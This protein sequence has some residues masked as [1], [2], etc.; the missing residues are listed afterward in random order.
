MNNRFWQLLLVG[1]SL[2]VTL[3][4]QTTIKLSKTTLYERRFSIS[5]DSVEMIFQLPDSFLIAGSDSF[6]LDSVWLEPGNDYLLDLIKGRLI[7]KKSI[8]KGKILHLQYE[9]LPLKLPTQFYH[10]RLARLRPEDDNLGK[11]L[12][13][14]NIFRPMDPEPS[15][16]TTSNLQKSGSIVR[17]ISVGSNQG[18]KLDSGLR[19][20]ISGRI[21]D[22][23]DVIAALTDQNTPIQPEGNTQSLQEIDKVFVQV[24]SNQFEATLGDYQLQF[25]SGEF[26]RYARKLQGAM[27]MV[28]FNNVEVTFSGAISRGQYTTNQFLGQEGNQGPYQLKGTQGQID[29]IV[30]AGTERVWIDGQEMTRGETNDYVIEYGNGQIIFTRNRL[31]TAESRI[32]VDFQYSDQKF[33]R[34]LYAGQVKASFFNQRLQ[35]STLYL[36]ESDDKDNPLDF[37]LTPEISNRLARAGDKM[38]SAYVESQQ[39][40]GKRKGTYIQVD[41]ADVQFYRYVGSEKGDYQVNFSF[42][43]YGRG[44]YQLQGFGKYRFVGMG[45]GS[46]VAKVL[47][48]PAISQNLVDFNLKY[49]PASFFEMNQELAISHFD[50]NI[51]SGLDDQDNQGFAYQGL[52][53]LKPDRIKYLGLF[54]LN[55]KFRYINP[56]FKNIDRTSEVEFNRKW[57]LKN[58]S[59]V[60]EAITE[61]NGSYTPWQPLDFQL[62]FGEIE[63]GNSFRSSRYEFNSQLKAP[64]LPDYQYRLEFIKSQ[65]DQFSRRGSWLRQ[66]SQVQYAF[67]KLQPKLGFEQEINKDNFANQIHSTGTRFDQFSGGLAYN[68]TKKVALSTNF[69]QRETQDWMQEKFVPQSRALTQQYQFNYSGSSLFSASVNYTH[70]NKNFYGTEA[71][72]RTDLAE[73]MMNYNPFKRAITANWNYQISNTQIAKR[74]R[75][76]LEVPEGEGAYRYDPDLKE[77]V[78][79]ALGN[80]EIRIVNT[81]IYTPVIELKTSLNLKIQFSQFFTK[82]RVQPPVKN[83]KVKKTA[84]QLEETDLWDLLKAVPWQNVVKNL[85]SETLIRIEERTRESDVAAIYG[86]NL[87][88]FQTD[89][90]IFGTIFLRETCYIGKNSRKFS[91]RLQYQYENTTNRQYIEGGEERLQTAA[92]AQL[93]SNLSNRMST[94][95]EYKNGRKRRRFQY[96]GRENR[97]VFSQEFAIDF[98][99]RPW[100]DLELALKSRFNDDTDQFPVETTEATLLSL[101]P[102]VNYAFRAKGRLSAQYEWAQVKSNKELLPYEMVNGNSDG[103]SQ[104]WEF[105]FN[106]RISKNVQG[107]LSYNGRN[108]KRRGGIIHLGRAEVRA[109]F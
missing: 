18:L 40:V 50:Q 83:L 16:T 12:Q 90:T 84:S 22:K 103:L 64:N 7:F 59:T 51:Y 91:L 25:E 38:D 67:W 14:I 71:D 39:F 10:Q 32:T 61:I 9:H 52:I 55:G 6:Q 3:Q 98:S 41:S 86:L 104:R 13:M 72:K 81:S 66:N 97:D 43:G 96:P 21:A 108:E 68:P 69:S 101:I 36:Q 80:Y 35:L 65:D 46:Y 23:V 75:Q 70:R 88:K 19:M 87:H 58:I 31:I 94:Q 109:F 27:G 49:M 47:L 77:F 60:Q 93:T 85:S 26:G 1:F 29:I 82:T 107:S 79:D 54:N 78:P 42:I 15:L 56:Q 24:K 105:T 8:P 34:N 44:D 17:G 62:N 45:N 28:K 57:D 30:I 33:R 20:Q 74:E 76:Y 95:L 99:Y 5:S 48:Y 89:S 37:T 100:S 73:L 4:A 53:K 11:Q 106:Y 102:R 63:K 92:S 2:A